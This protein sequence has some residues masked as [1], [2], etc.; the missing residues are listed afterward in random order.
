MA[1][2]IY[3]A[4]RRKTW[5]EKLAH[6]KDLPKVVKLTGAAAKRWGG[7]TLAIAAPREIDAFM[8]TIPRGRV[9]TI[10]ELRAAVARQHRAEVGCPITTGIFSWIAAHAAEEAA[11]AGEK[12][13]TPYWRTLKKDG[14]LNPKYPGGVSAARR[15]LAAEGHA[16]IAKGR[17][18]L[19]RDYEAALFRPAAK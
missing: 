16:F 11:A 12:K 10:N 1:V 17:R 7:T 14:E 6:D 19:V 13:I 4:T 15:Q 18:V 3:A 2:F 9:T 8:R 5:A